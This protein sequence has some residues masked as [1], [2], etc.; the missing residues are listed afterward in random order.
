V[1]P[2]HR[3]GSSFLLDAVQSV[4]QTERAKAHP[5][6]ELKAYISSPLE[7]VDDVLRHW[8]V[9]DCFVLH[10]SQNSDPS[11]AQHLAANASS[12]GSRLLADSRFFDSG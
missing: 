5:R 7:E 6:D 9:S 8:G 4:K 1:A 11:L 12:D 2:L 3:Y 10:C